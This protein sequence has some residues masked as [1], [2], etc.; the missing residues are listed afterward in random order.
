MLGFILSEGVEIIYSLVK[1]SVNGVTGIYYWYYEI[2]E[3]K[4]I[5][6]LEK[7]IIELENKIK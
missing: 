5:K 4:Q 1:I 3:K 2:D 7:R 6:D